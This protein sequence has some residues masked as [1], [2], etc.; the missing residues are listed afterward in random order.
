MRFH[1][2][3][4]LVALLGL[5]HFWIAFTVLVLGRAG[6]IDQRGIDNGA[7]AQRQP[8]VTQIAIDHG[9][10]AG[11][12]LVFLR[13]SAEVED[14]GFVGNTLQIQPGELPQDGGLVQCLLHRWIAITEPV[15]H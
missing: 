7:L 6:R 9:Q 13:Q 15:L 12:Q 11:S 10:D 14:G 2:E 4:V 5:V 3:I 8:S 1:A